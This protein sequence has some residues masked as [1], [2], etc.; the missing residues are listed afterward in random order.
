MMLVSGICEPPDVLARMHLHVSQQFMLKNADAYCGTLSHPKKR[1]TIM[2]EPPVDEERFIHRPLP[3]PLATVMNGDQ[4]RHVLQAL[5]DELDAMVRRNEPDLEMHQSLVVVRH[6]DDWCI[7]MREVWDLFKH[8][9]RLPDD[10]RS[11]S[12]YAK[13]NADVMTIKKFM[14]T[15]RQLH[16]ER[17]QEFMEL[18]LMHSNVPLADFMDVART[19]NLDGCIAMMLDRFAP[20]RDDDAWLIAARYN[21]SIFFP[22]HALCTWCCVTHD[23]PSRV[24]AVRVEAEDY[25][26]LPIIDDDPQCGSL[27]DYVTLLMPR[28][29]SA[30]SVA[31]H[32]LFNTT[33]EDVWRPHVDEYVNVM[34]DREEM[35]DAWHDLWV[36]DVEDDEQDDVEEDHEQEGEEDVVMENEQE[37]EENLARAD[38]DFRDGEERLEWRGRDLE[39]QFR[40]AA[41]IFARNDN[42]RP[43]LS[44][45]WIQD[46][47][48]QLDHGVDA[49]DVAREWAREC[50][51]ASIIH[52]GLSCIMAVKI[53]MDHQG[54]VRARQNLIDV[55][56]LLWQR[57][58]AHD[59]EHSVLLFQRLM[60]EGVD[61]TQPFDDGIEDELEM[62]FPG[63][64]NGRIPFQQLPAYAPLMHMIWMY[65][66]HA[67]F[68]CLLTHGVDIPDEV[69]MFALGNIFVPFPIRTA[70]V[71]CAEM[72]E[73]PTL[74]RYAQVRNLQGHVIEPKASLVQGIIL[75]GAGAGIVMLGMPD[76]YDVHETALFMRTLHKAYVD[77][78]ADDHHEDDAWARM[79]PD[80]FVRDVADVEEDVR[81]AL[82]DVADWQRLRL[83]GMMRGF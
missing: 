8:R 35:R 53:D 2:N 63:M 16:Q 26:R 70:C 65:D 10:D 51:K 13:W 7:T 17:V 66:W 45:T 25:I 32:A 58:R 49:E 48:E 41:E 50:R 62:D 77:Y 14:D 55:C 56:A 5:Q 82:G 40:M 57:F 59:G 44:R 30:Q 6:A 39:M 46:K 43:L 52:L 3:E 64:R 75:R 29:S 27:L 61:V 76:V 42:F 78:D 22:T 80:G 81:R 1:T 34:E 54:A 31:L 4:M 33:N 37:D 73:D 20:D 15:F 67:S 47:L 71:W 24:H 69:V 38:R 9:V 21:A 23:V 28:M 68:R 11:R 18:V 79:L 36:W 74:M 60:G 12:Q 83:L 19:F 72:G